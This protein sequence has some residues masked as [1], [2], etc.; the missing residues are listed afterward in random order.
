LKEAR[1]A[2][3]QAAELLEGLLRESPNEPGY[4]VALANTLLNTARTFSRRDQAA[5]WEPVYR[6]IVDLDRAAVH[7]APEK[8]LYDAELAL[9]LHAQGLF[10]LDV[11]RR[12]EGEAALQDALEIHKRLIARGQLKGYV[13]RYAA[14]N[15]VDVGRVLAAAGQVED[16]EKSYREAV[17]LLDR[18]VKELPRSVH[19]REE[20]AQ[21]LTVL[22]DFL[23]DPARRQEAKDIRRDVIHHYETLRAT[24]P[25]DP[26]YRPRLIRSYLKLVSLLW[27]L[28]LQSEAAEALRKALE[29]DPENPAVN[30]ELAWLLATSPELGL[31]DPALAVRL[32]QKAVDAQPK[33]G[34]YWNTLGAA[35][36]RH[37]DL[38]A[39]IDALETSMS[40]RDGGDSLDW[41][42]LA[43][44]H[45]RQGNRDEAR[46]WFDRAVQWMG[47]HKP[48]DE[49]L[50][51][52]RAEAEA[53]LDEARKP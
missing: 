3:D 19:D 30:N 11:G 35:D 8:P 40:L 7:T 46:T 43:M 23:K 14:R 27:E 50:R 4:Q 34:N 52:F 51:R 2:Y 18:T 15:F 13:E 28:G 33:S 42:F 44:A 1:E 49:E 47:K 17:S 39:A 32:A 12:S 10:F 16:A 36:Y 5:E 31:R 37:G 6:R 9:A 45:W 41:F 29:V 20:L 25:E 24:S 38:K 22:A 48:H 26:K 21:T 53:M